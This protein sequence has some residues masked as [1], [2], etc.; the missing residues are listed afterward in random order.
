MSPAAPQGDELAVGEEEEGPSVISGT[1]L[2]RFMSRLGALS[3]RRSL[4][5]WCR[6]AVPEEKRE[7]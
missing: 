4:S 7:L 5:L 1:E 3:L 6:L 2:E